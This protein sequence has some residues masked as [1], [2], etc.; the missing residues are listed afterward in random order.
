MSTLLVNSVLAKILLPT[1]SV[2]NAPEWIHLSLHNSNSHNPL[3][4]VKDPFAHAVSLKL[5]L[6]ARLRSLKSGN[7]TTLLLRKL[8]HARAFT[9]L[10]QRLGTGDAAAQDPITKSSKS[11]TSRTNFANAMETLATAA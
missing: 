11:L 9:I 7:A 4:T 10:L 6:T 3:V 5:K 2:A 8:A 1:N